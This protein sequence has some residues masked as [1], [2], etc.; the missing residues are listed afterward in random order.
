MAGSVNVRTGWARKAGLAWIGKLWLGEDRLGWQAWPGEVGLG[1]ESRGTARLR[2]AGRGMASNAS[3]RLGVTG[4]GRAGA[5]RHG[6]QRL[7]LAGT[8][9]VRLGRRG[10]SGTGYARHGGQA[11][12]DA[13]GDGGC[14]PGTAGAD[15][16]DA[17]RRGLAGLGSAGVARRAR[18]GCARRDLRRR[19]MAGQAWEGWAASR[20]D[21][22][23]MAGLAGGGLGRAARDE[24]RSG[25]LGMDRF[26]RASLGR[27]GGVS[28]GT[29]WCGVARN[30][31]LICYSA[32]STE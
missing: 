22:H 30:G 32:I 18:R 28:H 27:Q 29:K 31:R 1:A 26:G 10:L 9:R 23:G 16:P 12:H 14:R 7:V 17:E 20:G 15:R 6:D 25:R 11:R 21:R 3:A 8:D 4:H 2:Q 19:V 5:A 24:A 13:D